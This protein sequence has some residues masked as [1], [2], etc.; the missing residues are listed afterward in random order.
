MHFK[1]GLDCFVYT[2]LHTRG[3]EY[4]I[5]GFWKS[6]SEPRGRHCQNVTQNAKCVSALNFFFLYRNHSV[7][8][9]ISCVA[10]SYKYFV[11][12]FFLKLI[13]AGNSN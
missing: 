8:K 4:M 5:A 12:I 13:N 1:S 2:I 7:Y 11:T 10:Y 3:A 9:L 6:E